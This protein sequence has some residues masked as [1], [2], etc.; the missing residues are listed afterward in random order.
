[1]KDVVEKT[2]VLF[3]AVQPPAG[4]MPVVMAAGAAGILLHE[5][6]GHGM[7]GRL[8]PQERLR[9]AEAAPYVVPTLRFAF[10]LLNRKNAPLAQVRK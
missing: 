8:Q 1:V 4:E 7:G 3:D 9:R 5:A 6:I 10:T 2:V